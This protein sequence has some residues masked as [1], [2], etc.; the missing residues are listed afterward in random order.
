MFIQHITI[1]IP[2]EVV[3]KASSK[4]DFLLLYTNHVF[5][6]SV[7]KQF[8]K[9]LNFHH[10][11]NCIFSQ[12]SISSFFLRNRQW[13]CSEAAVYKESKTGGNNTVWEG[14]PAYKE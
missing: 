7:Y 5:I 14:A 10:V 12:I 11:I 9:Q 13:H 8:P 4:A 1:F 2:A 3:V 6:T